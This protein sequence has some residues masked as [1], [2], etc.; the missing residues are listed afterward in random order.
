MEKEKEKENEEKREEDL[1]RQNTDLQNA[2]AAAAM[3]LEG[4]PSGSNGRSPEALQAA[5]QHLVHCNCGSSGHSPEACKGFEQGPLAKPRAELISLGC[6][7]NQGKELWLWKFLKMSSNHAKLIE[8]IAE[9]HAAGECTKKDALDLS[10][11]LLEERPV[12]G[13]A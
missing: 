9:Q 8:T 2:Q 5:V 3:V 11:Q 12:G 13:I 6:L 1:D 4:Q 7:A 10:K